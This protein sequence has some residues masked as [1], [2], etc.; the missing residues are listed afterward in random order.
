MVTKLS[1]VK[2][3]ERENSTKIKIKSKPCFS[4]H[5]FGFPDNNELTLPG[6]RVQGRVT[7]I[8]ALS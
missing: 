2:E 5:N 3:N 4:L 7:L 8:P 6:Q 1:L